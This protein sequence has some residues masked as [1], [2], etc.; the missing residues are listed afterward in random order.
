MYVNKYILMYTYSY[1]YILIHI[2]ICTHVHILIYRHTHTLI[3]RYLI[4]GE[5]IIRIMD[6][7]FTRIQP[8]MRPSNEFLD[9]FKEVPESHIIGGDGSDLPKKTRKILYFN[10]NVL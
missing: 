9:E 6:K 3:S 7:K 4:Q 5:A 10:R 1:I 2:L 8:E